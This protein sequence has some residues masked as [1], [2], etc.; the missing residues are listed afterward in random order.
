M[1][2]KGSEIANNLGIV[3]S[4]IYKYLKNEIDYVKKNNK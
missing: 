1:Y 4:K 3:D 2:Q